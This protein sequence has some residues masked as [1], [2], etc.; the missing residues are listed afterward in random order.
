MADVENMEINEDYSVIF[1]ELFCVAAQ[2]LAEQIHEPLENIGVLYN[3]IMSTGTIE[4]KKKA[5]LPVSS[6]SN[7]SPPDIELG[8]TSFV[9]GRGQLLFVVRLA[10]KA[11]TTRLQASGFRF[12]DVQNIADPLARSMQVTR[13]ELIMRVDGMREY[14]KH[15]RTLE[16][17]VHMACFAIRPLIRGF[18]H[19]LV[20]KNATNLL[21]TI[22]MPLNELDSTQ[23]EVLR[24]MD[25]WTVA[26]CLNWLRAKLS[27][28][29]RG[30]Q[31]FVTQLCDSLTALV[32]EVEDPFF[33]A[34]RFVGR[35][36]SAPCRSLR[37]GQP[38]G[39]ATVLAFRIMTDIHTSTSNARLMFS[40]YNFF[41]CQQLVYKNAPD[42]GIFAR[43]VHREFAPILNG[44]GCPYTTASGHSNL[45]SSDLARDAIT[46]N[47]T[48]PGVKWS[49]PFSSRTPTSDQVTGDN[50][51][52]KS[53]VNDGASQAYGGIT[54]R[55]EVR[56]D[57]SDVPRDSDVDVERR[58]LGTQK[59]A[60]VTV[61]ES[62]TFVDELF[63]LTVDSSRR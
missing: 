30:E 18:F 10:N 53:L 42:H 62:E 41:K 45:S 48:S 9:F 25:G 46:R 12:A 3:D 23:I 24:Q 55:N 38:P 57:I 29:S 17:G 11:E 37:D 49:W 27:F 28:N 51:S 4:N 15:D 56:V 58:T 33:L 26:A 43:E 5:K 32:Q 50:S 13:E 47:P 7:D 52:E 40:P 63:A 8:R 14:S 34:A 44:K 31:L 39:K 6:G 22:R 54:V 61:T 19:I 20:C 36:I 35:P 2:D 1:K 59:S 16:P 60:S 21:P